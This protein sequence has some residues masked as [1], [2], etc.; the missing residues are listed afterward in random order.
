MAIEAR[1]VKV[2]D[3][4]YN[5]SAKSLPPPF[6]WVRV[7]D[8]INEGSNTR[9]ITRVFETVK[10]QREAVIVRTPKESDQ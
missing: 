4:I 1:Q 9:I 10:H 6:H 7:I 5:S 2:G 3:Y 8:V